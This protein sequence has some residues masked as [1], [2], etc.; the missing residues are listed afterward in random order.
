MAPAAPAPAGSRGHSPHTQAQPGLGQ[1]CSSCHHVVSQ[2]L[3][4]TLIR[5]QILPRNKRGASL[6]LPSLWECNYNY[7]QRKGNTE[8]LEQI[9]RKMTN[10]PIWRTKRNQWIWHHILQPL[11]SSSEGSYLETSAPILEGRRVQDSSNSRWDQSNHMGLRALSLSERPRPG[12]KQL[13]LFCFF[14]QAPASGKAL[15]LFEWLRDMNM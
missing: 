7:Q 9:S 14:H 10:T 2:K 3:G 8:Q 6:T 1:G 11:A 13:S 15:S 5:S 12:F 4:K